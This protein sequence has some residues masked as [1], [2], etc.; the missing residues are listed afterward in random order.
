MALYVIL[1]VRFVIRLMIIVM[2]PEN[3]M[4]VVQRVT[5]KDMI[6]MLIQRSMNLC[7]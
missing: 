2:I 5:T 7:L 4:I 6:K 1:N 3:V